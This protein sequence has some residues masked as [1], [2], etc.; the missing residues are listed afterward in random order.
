MW[1]NTPSNLY[2][3]ILSLV[4]LL[5]RIASLF[6]FFP[7]FICFVYLIRFVILVCLAWVIT[8]ISFSKL[9][10]N[11]PRSS[12]LSSFL[13]SHLA[14]STTFTDLVCVLPTF[15]KRL[16]NVANMKIKC[17]MLFNTSLINSTYEWTIDSTCIRMASHWTPPPRIR[18]LYRYL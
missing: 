5:L 1:N 7:F 6:S 18:E 8:Q 11:V 3:M 15:E 2:A 14:I 12:T 17:M 10:V 9:V 4:S 13:Y 16:I